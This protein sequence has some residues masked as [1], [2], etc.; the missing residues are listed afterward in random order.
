MLQHGTMY[1]SQFGS[2]NINNNYNKIGKKNTSV[3]IRKNEVIEAP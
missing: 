2:Q 1:G 3:K